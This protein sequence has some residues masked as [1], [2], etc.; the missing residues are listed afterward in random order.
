MNTHSSESQSPISRPTVHIETGCRLHFGLFSTA[1]PEGR[2][3]QGAGIM[4]DRP[5]L[6]LSVSVSTKTHDQIE[7]SGADS[8]ELRT[9]VQNV[10]NR[11]RKKTDL[12]QY[13]DVRLLETIPLHQGLGAGTQLGLA[14]GRAVTHLHGIRYCSPTEL[15]SWCGRGKRSSIGAYG[16]ASGGFFLDAGK[17]KPEEEGV[18]QSRY[19]VP[20]SWRVLLISPKNEIGLA[21]KKEAAAFKKMPALKPEDGLRLEQ[22][23]HEEMMPALK[24][25][26]LEQFNNAVQEFGATV[27]RQFS[28][29]QHGVYATPIAE[30]IVEA[31]NQKGIGGVGQSSWG[32]TLF[33][34]YDEADEE[35]VLKAARSIE[36][37]QQCTVQTAQPKNDGATLVVR[38]C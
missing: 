19:D 35:K 17:T 27:G 28:E 6:K 38:A 2:L 22:L 20:S 1:P 14:V 36:E 8:E 25:G 34:F 24:R 26:S 5:G 29:F 18:C 10:L 7:S 31:L 3:F 37:I 12:Q 4:I 30:K 33:A 13:W 9:R 21:G 23:L 11:L 16:F 32:P 15:A